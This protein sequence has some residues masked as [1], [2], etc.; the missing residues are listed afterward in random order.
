MKHCVHILIAVLF[1]LSCIIVTNAAARDI[2]LK[3]ELANNNE[4]SGTFTLILYGRRHGNDIE[5]VAFL[6]LE[7][8]PYTFDPYTPEY[9]YKKTTGVSAADALK[10]AE[11]FVGWHSSFWRFQLS[12]ILDPKGAVIGYELRPIYNPTEF[13]VSDVMNIHYWLKAKTISITIELIPMV[14]K[15]FQHLGG[16]DSKNGSK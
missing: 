5:T 12:R 4:V 11:E 10:K 16:G 14:K 13:G 2:F 9:N 6:D 15:K 3:T 1:A 7:G 8:D